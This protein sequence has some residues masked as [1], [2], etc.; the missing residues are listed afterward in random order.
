MV[1]RA[2]GR[3]AETDGEMTRHSGMRHLAQASDVQ[4][5]IGESILTIVVMDTGFGLRAPRNDDREILRRRRDR[6]FIREQWIS[7]FDRGLPRRR[8]DLRAEQVG[9]VEH[10]TGAL[11]EGRDGRRRC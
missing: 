4:L 5:H 8:I 11:A 10:V 3:S 7:A 1:A 6:F 9:D 2:R